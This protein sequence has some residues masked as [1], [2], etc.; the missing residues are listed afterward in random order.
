M[1]DHNGFREVHAG[2]CPN[3]RTEMRALVISDIQTTERN[4][5]SEQQI[6]VNDNLG[7]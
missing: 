3:G 5:N 1:L 4:L 6:A 2:Q 7:L